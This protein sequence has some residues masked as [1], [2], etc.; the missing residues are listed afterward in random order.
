MQSLNLGKIEI[1]IHIMEW[2]QTKSA[3]FYV[4]IEDGAGVRKTHVEKAIYQSM[5][6][7]D[8]AQHGEDPDTTHCIVLAPTGMASYHIKGNTLHS[9]LH[10]DLNKARPMPLGNSEKNTLC[11]KYFETKAVFYDE[12]SMV[13]RDLFNKSEY[14]PREIFATGKTFG[15]LHVIVV[16]DFF[17]MTPVRDPY[18]FKDDFKDYGPLSYKPVERSLLYIY[19]NR[20]NATRGQKQFCEV[21]NRLRK[22]N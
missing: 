15:N 6:R 3:P 14:R 1:C 2:I 8:G 18:V 21:L 20:N 10:I 13:G 17:Q 16:G 11:A 4:F 22:E 19:I 12:M 7:F 5:E 9:G